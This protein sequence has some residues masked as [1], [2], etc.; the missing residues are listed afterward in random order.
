MHNHELIL[1]TGATGFVGTQLV[2]ELLDRQPAAR[3]ALI[4]RPRPGQTA[5]QRAESIVPQRDRAR[6]Q[7]YS[8]DVTLPNFGLDASDYEQL[9]AETTRV[10]HSA[11][12]VRFDH[13]LEEARRMNVEGTRH[14][15]DF[16]A[17]MPQLRS[18]VY[19]GTAYVA[20]QRTGLVREDELFVK[21]GYRNT[22][23]QSKAEAE[24]LV[25]SRMGLTP[26]R[27]SASKHH[28]WRFP[29]RSDF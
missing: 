22:Y 13:S 5:E 23:E 26:S 27:N 20:G 3:L 12:T 24:A 15:L 28:S 6:V 25:R 18:F 4:V 1:I 8:G 17:A 19:V 9:A 14:L 7:A 21:Q 11:A 16:A 2:R 29:H 10:I